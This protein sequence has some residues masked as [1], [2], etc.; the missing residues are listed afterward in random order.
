MFV[1]YYSEV[2]RP[3][4]DVAERCPLVLGQIEG[5]AESS[6]R[7]GEA[8]R[9]KV[10]PTSEGTLV[11][12]TVRMSVGP[13]VESSDARRIPLTWEA[14]GTPGLFPKMDAEL[15]IARVS[16]DRTQVKIQGHYD[17]PLGSLGRLIDKALLHRVAEASTKALVDRIVEELSG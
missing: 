8:I 6:Y 13:A 7:D 16:D 15:V 12:K 10:G 2:A 4:E 17:P 1:Q 9:G 5:W 3:Y 14:T 11:A